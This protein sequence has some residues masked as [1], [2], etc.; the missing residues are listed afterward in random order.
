MV[1]AAPELNDNKQWCSS[2]NDI[3][4]FLENER[5]LTCIQDRTQV[6]M[7]GRGKIQFYGANIFVF[8][9]C[10]KQIFLGRT[11]FGGTQ[12]EF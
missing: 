10:L 4:T 12:N 9:I 3:L 7:F 8:I 6:L 1:A 11:K 5:R 2:M